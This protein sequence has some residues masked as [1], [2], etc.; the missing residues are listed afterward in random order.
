MTAVTTDGAAQRILTRPYRHEDDFWRVR[1][2]LVQTFP[3]TGLGFNW[4]IRRWD[5]SNFHDADSAAREAW[6]SKIH[7]WETAD[8]QLAGAAHD[9]GAPGYP[10]LQVHPDYRHLVE[11]DMIAWAEAH[12]AGT[13]E[14]G[15]RFATLYVYEYDFPRRRLLAERGY[16]KLEAGWVHRRMYFGDR[17]LP[18]PVMADGYT[19]RTVDPTDAG[20]CDQIAAL[21]NAAFN[22]QFH[23]GEDFAA[24]G[25]H[26]PCFRQD[27]HLVAV[28]PDGTFAAHVGVIYDE[29]NRRGLYEPVCT[30]PDHRRR[31]LAQALMFEGLRR[32]KALGARQIT[33]ETGDAVPANRLYES[34]G[35]T[36]AYQGY[37][38]RRVW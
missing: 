10:Q 22:R 4:E 23:K 17:P 9:E 35:F 24:F 21:L 7:L 19:L 30:H 27:L 2:L 31:G 11:A 37:A 26:A 20:D 15:K 28:A 38:W 14:D 8:G 34:I 13:T 3:I 18:E 25:Q 33:V 12:L 1:D 29:A 6:H 36:E 16:Q 32:A 5:G